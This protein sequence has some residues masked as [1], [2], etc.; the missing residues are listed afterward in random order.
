MPLVIGP[1]RWYNP[2]MSLRSW[3]LERVG[4]DHFDLVAP[5]YDQV[6]S[7]AN[8]APLLD[9]L[10]LPP[11]GRLLD[12]GGGTGRVTGGLAGQVGQLVL[13]DASLRMLRQAAAKDGLQPANALAEELP[14]PPG[15]FD[16]ILMVDALHHVADQRRTAGELM[17]VLA[18]GGRIVIEEPNLAHTSVKLVA[19]AEKLIL[20]RSHFLHPRRIQAIFEALG[21]RVSVHSVPGDVNAWVVVVKPAQRGNKPKEAR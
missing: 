2:A 3:L 17:R 18:P 7:P 5:Y 9:L 6:I 10:D 19:L 11:T 1:G 15:Y 16:R 20:M 14:F 21:G 4:L 12:V 13:A 8:L